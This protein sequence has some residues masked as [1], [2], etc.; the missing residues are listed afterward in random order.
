VITTHESPPNVQ[1]A[2]KVSVQIGAPHF[3][4]DARPE[5]RTYL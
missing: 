3:A 5:P 1:I 2:V 4:G